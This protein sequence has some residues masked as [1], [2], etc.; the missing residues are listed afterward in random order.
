MIH[1][2]SKIT[3]ETEIN[4]HLMVKES[5]ELLRLRQRYRIR[6]K[7]SMQQTYNLDTLTHTI[8]AGASLQTVINQIHSTKIGGRE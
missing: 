7:D 8:D 6:L 5:L 1:T 3:K 4:N 2:L